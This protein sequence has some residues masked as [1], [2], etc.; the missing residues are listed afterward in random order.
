MANQVRLDGGV[1][2]VVEPGV[3]AH[4]FAE[5]VTRTDGAGAAEQRT[6]HPIEVEGEQLVAPQA[7]PQLREL[8]EGV[9]AHSVA[10]HPDCVH[11]SGRGADQQVGLDPFAAEG[12]QHP[13]LHGAEAAA[14]GEHERGPLP[15]AVRDR[16]GAVA[17]RLGSQ[18]CCARPRAATALR[19]KLRH[20]GSLF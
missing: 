3:L 7:P 6:E 16:S 1:G 19:A 10:G 2:E 9:A 18:P 17:G 14:S 11:G 4:Q 13:H 20:V 15:P 5:P 12:L 8:P